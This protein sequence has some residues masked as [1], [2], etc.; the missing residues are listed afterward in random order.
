[1]LFYF[2]ETLNMFHRCKRWVQNCRRQDLIGKSPLYLQKN[3]SICN[4]HFERS[5]FM[6]ATRDNCNL[7]WNAV[8]TIFDVP[9]PPKPLEIKR[10]LP[11]RKTLTAKRRL[12]KGSCDNRKCFCIYQVNLF[13]C[14]FVCLFVCILLCVCI[15]KCVR[16]FS[17]MHSTLCLFRFY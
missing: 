10:P 6:D 16:V 12:K 3:C 2:N 7:I 1:M 8:P 17:F 14:L 5:Q 13:K 11:Q 15:C 4:V 9:N